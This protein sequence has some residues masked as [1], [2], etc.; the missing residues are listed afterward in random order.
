MLVEGILSAAIFFALDRIGG[1]G[2]G[3]PPP[4]RRAGAAPPSGHLFSLSPIQ[5]ARVTVPDPSG[6]RTLAPS[7]VASLLS[8]LRLRSVL[9]APQSP[10]PAWQLCP[11]RP[12]LE[13]AA[14]VIEKA[15]ERGFAVVASST[16]VLTRLDPSVPAVIMAVPESVIGALTYQGSLVVLARPRVAVDPAVAPEPNV[17]AKPAAVEVSVSSDAAPSAAVE[18]VAEE[19]NPA[20][21]EPASPKTKR[22]ARRRDRVAAPAAGDVGYVNGAARVTS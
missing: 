6:G 18:G 2:S 19:V 5:I 21:A 8:E 7:V 14:D 13:S 22:P 20:R 15:A 3:S 9:A 16:I 11:L 1:R 17:T 4:P 12:D 10:L